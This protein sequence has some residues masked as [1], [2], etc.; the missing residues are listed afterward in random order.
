MM[1]LLGRADLVS[2]TLAKIFES[3]E[4][5]LSWKSF[6][7]SEDPRYVALTLPRPGRLPYG[8]DFKKVDEFNYEES[9]DGADRR[10]RA[11]G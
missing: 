11:C 4:G 5:G 10:R 8:K 9:V 3:V 2:A 1:D 6:R 7:E